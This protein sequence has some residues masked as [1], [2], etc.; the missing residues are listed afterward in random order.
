MSPDWIYR[1]DKISAGRRFWT[2]YIG[3]NNSVDT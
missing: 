1:N 2:V 3:I